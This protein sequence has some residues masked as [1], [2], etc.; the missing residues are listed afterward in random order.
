[1]SLEEEK[2]QE[3]EWV[4]W[5]LKEEHNK[6]LWKIL[7]FWEKYKEQWDV[8]EREFWNIE[9]RSYRYEYNSDYFKDLI[10]Q[11]EENKEKFVE[12]LSKEEIDIL[13]SL[14][15]VGKEKFYRQY[16]FSKIVYSWNIEKKSDQRGA[17]FL[18]KWNIEKF[19]KW[20][21]D[22]KNE[23]QP[24]MTINLWYNNIWDEWVKILTK[25]WKD[26]LKPWMKIDLRGN[27]ISDKK[28]E[29]LKSWEKTYRDNWINCNVEVS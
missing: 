25:E 14:D 15:G 1:M 3:N 7:A 18:D 29:E 8:M 19:K 17:T 5:L 26:N 13:E 6:E 23:L 10:L 4:R 2:L 9:E 20:V 12:W 27:D 24:W 16:L 28:K 22:M 11:Y 21:R